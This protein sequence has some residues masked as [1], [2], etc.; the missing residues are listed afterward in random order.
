MDDFDVASSENN[1][2]TGSSDER[3]ALSNDMNVRYSS[4]HEIISA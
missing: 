3:Y 2:A 4:V 1:V